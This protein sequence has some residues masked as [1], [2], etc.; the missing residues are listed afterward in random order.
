MPG[1]Y[2]ILPLMLWTLS[3][4]SLLHFLLKNWRPGFIISVGSVIACLLIDLLFL[5]LINEDG[6]QPEAGL[7]VHPGAAFLILFLYTKTSKHSVLRNRKNPNS[8][9]RRSTWYIA[10][11]LVILVLA[12]IIFDL[13][14]YFNSLVI[15]AEKPPYQ[16]IGYW[17]E[18]G[19]HFQMGQPAGLDLNSRG[20]MV[21]LH[22]ARRRWSYLRNIPKFP[23]D[24]HTILVLDTATGK[25]LHSWGAG[26]F[27]M[28]HGLTIDRNDHVWVTDVGLHQVFKFSA[29]GELMM[30][31]GEKG[32]P[33]NDSMHFNQPTDIAFASDGSFYVSDGYGNSRIMKF[34]PEGRFLFQWG[35]EG[36]G[37]GEFR[38]PHSL[39]MDSSG[40]IY[41]A[42][43]GNHRVQ[44][45]TPVGK[46]LNQWTQDDWGEICSVKINP[47]GK[48]MFLTDDPVSLGIFHPGSRIFEVNLVQQTNRVYPLSVIQKKSW[49]H[50]FVLDQHGNIYSG[51]IAR[52]RI[53]KFRPHK[54]LR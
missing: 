10:G 32:K 21:V 29:N 3:I 18:D 46:F 40:N 25:V 42:D 7:Y 14:G 41:V 38:I 13:A 4:L 1:P 2:F 45:F 43:R 48:T 39:D 51:D 52:N 6:D 17:P 19:R 5:S 53:F 49:F 54:S 15:K 35:R 12:I 26:I 47:G 31:L 34:S 24:Q 50:D 44:A 8:N 11:G 23:I 20:E 37:E 16:A 30:S 27:I 28:P 36:N 9:R 22:R 33:G